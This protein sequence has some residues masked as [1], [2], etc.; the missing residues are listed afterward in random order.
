MNDVRV[1]IL[2][3]AGKHFCAGIDL[4]DAAPTFEGLS[5]PGSGE[6]TADHIH[7]FQNNIKAGVDSKIPVIGVLHGVAYGLALDLIS[8]TSIRIATET[9][10]L[11]IKEIDI[12]IMA[13][14]GSLE[15]LPYLINNT[16]KLNQYALTGEEFSGKDAKELGLVSEVLPTKE[17]A[18]NKAVELAKII[19]KKYPPAVRGT[20]KSLDLITVNSDTA[21]K[22]LDQVKTDNAKLM[23]D[24][25]FTK[26]FTQAM[27]KMNSKL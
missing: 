15:R 5:E 26:F 17:D 3:G 25:A 4:K 13:D 20:K 19:A 23:T 22:G 7:E 10:R 18:F 12:G 24:P 2:S 16:S 8:A 21:N 1:I 9:T 11:S 14:I 6:K 27:K